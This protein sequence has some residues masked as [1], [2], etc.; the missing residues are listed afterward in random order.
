MLLR[1]VPNRYIYLQAAADSESTA[2]QLERLN[3][4][5]SNTPQ[6]PDPEGIKKGHLTWGN[7]LLLIYH[8]L[9]D[10]SLI[11][12]FLLHFYIWKSRTKSCIIPSQTI[13]K[14]RFT[15]EVLRG[16]WFLLQMLVVTGDSDTNL[17]TM[18]SGAKCMILT[19][20]Y[21][22]NNSG[23]IN[24]YIFF[25]LASRHSSSWILSMYY[26]NAKRTYWSKSIED[27]KPVSQRGTRTWWQCTEIIW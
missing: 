3:L 16:L 8:E 11:F 23:Q 24:A 13:S 5:P 6:G 25:F 1:K 19:V 20:P 10:P 21:L 14:R 7:N 18:Y 26:K 4:H 15:K 22:A 17:E 12:Y 27:E 2:E 9:K